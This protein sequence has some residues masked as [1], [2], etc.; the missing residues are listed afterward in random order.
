MPGVNFIQAGLS[1][2]FNFQLSINDQ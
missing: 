1:L 2:I